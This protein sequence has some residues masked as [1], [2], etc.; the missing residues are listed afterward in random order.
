VDLRALE[1]A[2]PA[3]AGMERI[4]L[5]GRGPLLEA[6]RHLLTRANVGSI[7]AVEEPL[8]AIGARALYERRVALFSSEEGRKLSA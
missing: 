6:Y 4:V 1:V 7:E 5:S 2:L 3:G 8:G